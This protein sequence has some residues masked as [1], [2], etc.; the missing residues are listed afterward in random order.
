M[1]YAG[2]NDQLHSDIN[3]AHQSIGK[4]HSLKRG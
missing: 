1:R 3:I 2:N 4:T